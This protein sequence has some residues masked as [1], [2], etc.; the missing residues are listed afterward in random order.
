MPTGLYAL[1][2]LGFSAQI[3][4]NIQYL[5]DGSNNWLEMIMACLPHREV[6]AL[7]GGEHTLGSYRV[8][9]VFKHPIKPIF[10]C[11][12]SMLTFFYYS[13]GEKKRQYAKEYDQK[14]DRATDDICGLMR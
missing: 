14:K 8:D 9:M 5:T 3:P 12:S 6:T 2:R 4:M 7:E 11:F 10:L 1:N 13:C